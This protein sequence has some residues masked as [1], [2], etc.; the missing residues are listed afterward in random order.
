[1]GRILIIILTL[2]CTRVSWADESPDARA[3]EN[4]DLAKRHYELGDKSFR[5]GDFQTA[6]RHFRE[7]YQLY[8]T[9]LLLWNLA[10]TYRQLSDHKQALFFYKQF[11]SADTTG[12]EHDAALKRIKE[13]EEIVEKERQAQEAPPAGPSKPAALETTA[14]PRSAAPAAPQASTS[15]N[16]REGNSPVYKKWW[17]WTAVGAVVVAGV[18]IGLGVG[19]TQHHGSTFDASLG[20]V[21][22]KALVQW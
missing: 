9:P 14:Q 22:P 12:A 8:P 13:L 7:A 6:A 1:M 4:R 11:V 18:A 3:A 21:G 17:L 10:Q 15:T 19:L 16:D 5:L 2:C 20:T